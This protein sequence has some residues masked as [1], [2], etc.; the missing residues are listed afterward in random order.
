MLQAPLEV[1]PLKNILCTWKGRMCI[2]SSTLAAKS[3]EETH[4]EK[5]EIEAIDKMHM[6]VPPSEQAAVTTP[7]S[8]LVCAT[9]NGI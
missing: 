5:K 3:E 7:H 8:P 2:S 6:V 4:L 9:C 1:S